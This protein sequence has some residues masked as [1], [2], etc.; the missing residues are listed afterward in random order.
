MAKIQTVKAESIPCAEPVE[1]HSKMKRFIVYIITMT[2]IS[3][4]YAFLYHKMSKDGTDFVNFTSFTDAVYFSLTVVST[5]GF[6]DVSPT[7]D[8]GRK[9]VSSQ[10][11]FTWF[12]SLYVAMVIF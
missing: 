8:F 11:Y 12:F 5:T 4:G 7:S 2:L 3:L 9:V 10:I 1:K 6:G